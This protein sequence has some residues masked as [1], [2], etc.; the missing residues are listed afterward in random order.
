VDRF[1]TRRA[2]RSEPRLLYYESIWL[3]KPPAA[4]PAYPQAGL[5]LDDIRAMLDR[6][7]SDAPT[8]APS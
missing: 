4:D 1:Q 2:L 3:L 5:T 8:S 6:L 7:E